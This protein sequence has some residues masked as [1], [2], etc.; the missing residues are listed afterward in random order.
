MPQGSIPNIRTFIRQRGDNGRYLTDVIAIAQNQ[1]GPNCGYYALNLVH[2]Y[3]SRLG[4]PQA[5]LP[6]RKGDVQPRAPL[7]LRELGMNR[8]LNDDPLQAFEVASSRVGGMFDGN[9]IARVSQLAGWTRSNFSQVA[10]RATYINTIVGAIDRGIPV[11]VGYDVRAGRVPDNG[12]PADLGGEHAHYATIMGYFTHNGR[13]HFV[14]K[15]WG[16]YFY[17]DSHLLHASSNQL[18]QFSGGQYAKIKIVRT[19]DNHVVF[20]SGWKREGE[21]TAHTRQDV[22]DYSGD[23]VNAGGVHVWVTANDGK[24]RT[25]HTTNHAGQTITYK[26]YLHPV[27]QMVNLRHSIVLIEPQTYRLAQQGA[28]WNPDDDHA[29]CQICNQNFKWNRRRHHCRNCGRVVCDTC[30]RARRR[31]I[32]P[33]TSSGFDSG[34][35][36]VRVCDTC[37]PHL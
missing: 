20:N 8:H 12:C 29:A 37:A 3:W 26:R 21:L 34:T 4:D 35:H 24:G 15:H 17:W 22:Q 1:R 30:S 31:M 16:A 32:N 14:A 36:N 10:N 6:A 13:R 11:I 7:S 25:T 33:L 18:Q 2:S 19:L 5:V 28:R 23:V 9:E 27:A